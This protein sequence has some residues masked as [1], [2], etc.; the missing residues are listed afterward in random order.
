[1][2]PKGGNSFS[3]VLNIVVAGVIGYP[4]KKRHPEATAPQAIASLPSIRQKAI[5]TPPDR[6]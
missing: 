2:P 1:M 5:V 6:H 3:R 4:A